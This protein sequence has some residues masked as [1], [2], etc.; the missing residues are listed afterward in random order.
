MTSPLP[1]VPPAAVVPQPAAAPGDHH[2]GADVLFAAAHIQ[3]VISAA[4]TKASVLLSADTVLAAATSSAIGRRSG[5]FTPQ[6]AGQ[7][8]F[9]LLFGA[10]ACCLGVAMIGLLAVVRPRTGVPA[11]PSRFA[12]PWLADSTSEQLAHLPVHSVR[13]EA[14]AEARELA[15]VARQKFRHFSSAL[16]WSCGALLGCTALLLIR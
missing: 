4:D 6:G 13:S 8:L 2:P 5:V 15:F 11:G 1:D 16:A 9:L 14:W 10:T 7:W 3:T 12:W